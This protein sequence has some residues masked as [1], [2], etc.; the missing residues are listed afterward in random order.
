MELKGATRSI[1]KTQ[2]A[3][4]EIITCS[5]SLKINGSSVLEYVISMKGHFSAVKR[6]HVDTSQQKPSRAPR[7]ILTA[8]FA[9]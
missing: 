2:Q 3:K 7:S 4:K 5:E 6:E 9:I 8:F 1:N